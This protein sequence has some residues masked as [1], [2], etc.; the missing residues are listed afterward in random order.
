M[1]EESWEQRSMEVF[2]RE[3]TAQNGVVDGYNALPGVQY[4]QLYSGRNT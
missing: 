4:L 1:K 2:L 3:S